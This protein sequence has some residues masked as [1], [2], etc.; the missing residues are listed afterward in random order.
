MSQ[1]NCPV[2]IMMYMVKLRSFTLRCL[3]IFQ[4]CGTN[5]AVVNTAATMPIVAIQFMLQNYH[6][7]SV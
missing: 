1:Q 5:A 7:T 2:N 4:A 6:I 3:I